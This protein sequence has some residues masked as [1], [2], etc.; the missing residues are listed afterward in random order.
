MLKCNSKLPTSWAVSE[1]RCNSFPLRTCPFILTHCLVGAFLYKQKFRP[2]FTACSQLPFSFQPYSVCM[3]TCVSVIALTFNECSWQTYC[4]KWLKWNELICSSAQ[5][6][7]ARSLGWLN[8]VWWCLTFSGVFN[9]EL[10]SYQSSGAKNFE[11]AARVLENLQI[12]CDMYADHQFLC[13]S[14][15]W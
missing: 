3:S 9:M 4:R 10:V 11:V 8:I 5:I 1:L 2:L 6:L 13:A 14:C 12:T 7:H 15:A